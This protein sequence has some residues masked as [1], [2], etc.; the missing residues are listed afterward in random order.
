[1]DVSWNTFAGRVP[2]VSSAL[3]QLG[4]EG[5]EKVAGFSENMPECL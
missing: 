4:V 2:D 5:Q 3:L 1:M